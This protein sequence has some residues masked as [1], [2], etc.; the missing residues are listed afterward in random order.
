LKTIV[1]ILLIFVSSIIASSYSEL[2]ASKDQFV[3]GIVAIDRTGRRF[4]SDEKNFYIQ[5]LLLITNIS[6]KDGIEILEGYLN[7]P[8]KWQSYINKIENILIK[9]VEDENRVKKE[10]RNE[11]TE[12]D[13]TIDKITEKVPE[14]D[15]NGYFTPISKIRGKS[16]SIF[17]NS[18]SKK[19]NSTGTDKK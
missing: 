13:S 10:N 2:L 4:S 8:F 18:I 12:K 7:K 11:F 9:K 19:K 14:K 17:N 5:E 1:S 6:A 15:R 3:A 16:H